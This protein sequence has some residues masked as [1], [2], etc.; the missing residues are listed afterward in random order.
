MILVAKF[1]SSYTTGSFSR[2]AELHEVGWYFCFSLSHIPF[3]NFSFVFLRNQPLFLFHFIHS[4]N[5]RY[6]VLTILFLI[7]LLLSYPSSFLSLFFTLLLHLPWHISLHGVTF[8]YWFTHSPGF[9]LLSL[10]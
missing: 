7:Q 2:R 5:I 3:H 1:L 4:K 10:Y 8:S 9:V 6:S